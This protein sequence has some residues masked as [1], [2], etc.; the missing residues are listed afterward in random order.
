MATRDGEYL[1]DNQLHPQTPVIRWDG[2]ASDDDGQWR[3]LGHFR[4]KTIHI[5]GTLTAGAQVLFE[6]TNELADF[7]TPTNQVTLKDSTQQE[8]II[9]AAPAIREVH[10]NPLYVRPRVIGGD[11]STEITVVLV[12][13]D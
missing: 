2:L 10:E 11:G 12:C 3:L 4:H 1:R 9:S 6:G 5:Y 13:R 8:I 7:V